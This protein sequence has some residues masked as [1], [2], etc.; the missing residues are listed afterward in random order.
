MN[1]QFI[2]VQQLQM[3]STKAQNT[4]QKTSKKATQK[5]RI[6]KLKKPLLKPSD[7]PYHENLIQF[8]NSFFN[9]Y[10]KLK[11][12]TIKSRPAS[13]FKPYSLILSRRTVSL[14]QD[15]LT[16]N[17]DLKTTQ[18]N[19]MDKQNPTEVHERSTIIDFFE[20]LIMIGHDIKLSRAN[21]YQ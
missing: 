6:P 7:P 17:Y 8:V 12:I 14:V 3:H 15:K 4:N 9:K 11:E 19:F 10:K 18:L 20:F 13:N 2:D 1:Q 16:F 5:P 21:V